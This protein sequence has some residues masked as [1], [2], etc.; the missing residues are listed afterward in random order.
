VRSLRIYLRE[1]QIYLWEVQTQCEFARRS[2][3]DFS[4]ATAEGD[5][6]GAF[7]HAHH[8]LS[9]AALIDKLL[10]PRENTRRAKVLAPFLSTLEIDIG[11]F[12][13]LRNHLE[14]FDERLDTWI[15]ADDGRPFFDMN[16]ITGSK[17][18][19]DHI[20]LRVLDG[21]VFKFMGEAFDLG[22]LN[23]DVTQL[24]EIVRRTLQQMDRNPAA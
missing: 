20:A 15:D 4:G 24:Y 14:H 11:P 19:P 10:S 22:A 17:G 6:F 23:S 1:V 16:I 3:A 7:Y 18:F 9:H 21:D 2:F 13:R 5:N 12:N 8:F